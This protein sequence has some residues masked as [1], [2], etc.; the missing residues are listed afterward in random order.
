MTIESGDTGAFYHFFSNRLFETRD[1]STHRIY[2]AGAF[3]GSGDVSGLSHGFCDSF[4]YGGGFISGHSCGYGEGD[5]V[6]ID[7]MHSRGSGF[8][9][10]VTEL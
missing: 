7:D 2:G 4:H 9:D 3:P 1:P 6:P 5:G 8:G 10:E